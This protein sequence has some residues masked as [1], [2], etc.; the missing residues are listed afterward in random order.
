M[1]NI[2][3]LMTILFLSFQSISMGM[4]RNDSL[5]LIN[6][7]EIDQYPHNAIL[8][9]RAEFDLGG[10]I[11]KR[12]GTCFLIGN[13]F[14]L[15]AAH[16]VFHK[17]IE[18]R[19]IEIYP[20][21]HEGKIFSS[22]S[23]AISSIGVK[24]YI[25]S[26]SYNPTKEKLDHLNIS[27]DYALIYFGE[28]HLSNINPIELTFYYTKPINQLF[29]CGYPG[30]GHNEH[31][32]ER[33]HENAGFPYEIEAKFHNQTKW[34]IGFKT[35]SFGGMSGSPIRFTDD[36]ILWKTTSILVG[37]V[38]DDNITYGCLLTQKKIN[39]IN[40][41]KELLLKSST[42]KEYFDFL[43]VIESIKIDNK[44]SP[45]FIGNESEDKY[46]KEYKDEEDEKCIVS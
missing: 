3:I 42:P 15:T 30:K 26:S 7:K 22:I 40:K 28:E 6:E 37:S 9:L 38:E 4:D 20:G 35:P 33:S 27:N 2:C 1:R 24:K 21:L 45:H 34:S 5:R 13:G 17:G 14:A 32:R 10:P 46:K 19:K 36:G 43:P 29:L 39:T 23:S 16:A 31:N 41:W 44:G 25:Y 18:A 12:T 11:I 8:A